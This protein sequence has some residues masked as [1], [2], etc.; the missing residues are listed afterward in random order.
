MIQ[1]Q[2]DL[3][4]VAMVLFTPNSM[5]YCLDISEFNLRIEINSNCSDDPSFCPCPDDKMC[6]KSMSLNL[7]CKHTSY[8]DM[9]SAATESPSVNVNQQKGSNTGGT[10]A[11]I[12]VSFIFVAVAVIV[13]VVLG[14]FL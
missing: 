1:S 7:T 9:F 2:A 12:L 5:L 14:I 6:P 3:G 11:G 4:N 10:V 13:L 8:G